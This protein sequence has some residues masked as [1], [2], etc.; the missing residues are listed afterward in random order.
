MIRPTATTHRSHLDSSIGPISSGLRS[1]GQLLPKRPLPPNGSQYPQSKYHS[2]DVH[3]DSSQPSGYVNVETSPASNNS[4]FP[5]NRSQ[6]AP[7][8]SINGGTFI[9][10]NV[11]NIHHGE[12]GDAFHDSAERY[13][14]PR[15]HPETRTKL[16]DVLWN[17]ACGIEPPRNWSSDD[18]DLDEPSHD[19]LSTG[20]TQPGS[21]ILWLN[22]PAGSGKSAVAQSF[23]QRLKDEGCLG[24]SFFFKRGHFSRGNAKKLFPTIAYQLALLL[25][26]LKHLI[27]QAAEND[28][29][30]VDR[31]LSYQ[32]QELIVEPCRR[33]H[34]STP[35]P[36]IIDGLDECDGDDIQQEILRS[37]S[38]TVHQEH[39]P[40]LFLVASRPESHIRETFSDPCLDKFHWPLNINQSF[41]D[42]YK[43]L[44]AEFGRIHRE[45][46]TM[47]AVPSPWPQTDIVEDLVRKSSGYFIYVSTVI[48]FIDD[49]RFRPVNRLEIILGIKSS[50]F[51]SPFDGLD[52]LYQLI[53][54]AFIAAPLCVSVCKLERLLELEMGD[55]RLILRDR[56]HSLIKMPSPEED[57]R[58][59]L[60]VH[61]ASLQDFL[62]SPTRSGPFSVSGSEYRTNVTY[63]I[64]KAFTQ[65]LDDRRALVTW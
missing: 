48:K 11:H 3:A 15:C 2:A 64:L 16:L 9:G 46:R 56:L 43:Y 45:H 60:R 27:S 5:W 35:V 28:P 22:G 4:A 50:N 49:K 1:S 33:S 19:F 54:S 6:N 52:Q 40:I 61:H 39:L 51:G 17:W 26:E 41:H 7:A 13:P 47:A 18:G 44:L 32:L 62:E 58:E 31:T 36:I 59:G 38:S 65:E 24:G 57:Q 25:P 14:Q 12:A 55:V 53:L 8:T 42:V 37:I 23:C 20:D 63:H 30:I 21:D 29:A 10:G 34:L